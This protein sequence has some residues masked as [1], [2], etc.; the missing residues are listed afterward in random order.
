MKVLVVDDDAMHREVLQEMINAVEPSATVHVAASWHE[1]LLHVA[2]KNGYTHVLTDT[3]LPELRA[4]LNLV[5]YIRASGEKE[6]QPRMFGM[7]GNGEYR[8][9]YERR[10]CGFVLKPVSM[11]WVREF[12]KA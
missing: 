8:A 12:L 6:S 4:G 1:A 9:E 11:E 2:Q 7:S 5:D 10:G 3:D